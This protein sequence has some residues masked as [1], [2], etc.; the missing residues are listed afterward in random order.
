VKPHI[1]VMDTYLN[2]FVDTEAAENAARAMAESGADV[3]SHSANAAGNGVIMVAKELG[4]LA[5]GDSFDQAYL[6]PDTVMCSTI[7]DVPQEIVVAVN[8][9]KT[10]TF[11]GGIFNL[12]MKEGAVDI[13]PYH[14]FEDKI[15]DDV[16]ALLDST[17]EKIIA[18]KFVVP[19]ITR[20]TL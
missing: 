2:S 7:Y 5:T 16:K 9:V 6:A 4:L 14:N 17:K 19:I 12:G 20:R 8:R 13:A 1:L 3:L 11:Y 10:S 15:P 18:G